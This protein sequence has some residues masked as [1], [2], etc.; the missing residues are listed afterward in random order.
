MNFPHEES[1]R[2]HHQILS[3]KKAENRDVIIFIEHA[4]GTEHLIQGWSA[5]SHIDPLVGTIS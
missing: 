5:S 4:E 3:T 1:E 2:I